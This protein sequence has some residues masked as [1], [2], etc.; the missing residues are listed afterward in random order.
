V[1]IVAK[2]AWNSTDSKP[3]AS[4]LAIPNG[5]AREIEHELDNGFWI[6][7]VRIPC[8]HCLPS[9][10]ELVDVGGDVQIIEAFAEECQG[11]IIKSE[12]D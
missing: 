8:E 5:I 4:E 12:S 9:F 2:E 11:I 3:M 1:P 10:F 7:S 6:F